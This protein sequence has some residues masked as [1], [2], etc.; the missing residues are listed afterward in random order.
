MTDEAH[1]EDFVDDVS[2]ARG[3]MVLADHGWTL[4]DDEPLGTVPP[5]TLFLAPERDATPLRPARADRHPAALPARARRRAAD[6]RRDGRP[7]YHDRR[8]D[9]D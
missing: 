8:R 6:P 7:D 4:P 1:G 5:P 2:V 9:A 3:N